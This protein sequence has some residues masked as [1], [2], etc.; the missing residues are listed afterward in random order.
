[1]G[2][3][4]VEGPLLLLFFLIL[5]APRAG[6]TFSLV[7]R[8]FDRESRLK[9]KRQPSPALCVPSPV[10]ARNHQH[11]VSMFLLQQKGLFI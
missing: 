8:V 5:T 6:W 11:Q 4:V 10:T 2:Q 9:I 3:D 1:M 7:D